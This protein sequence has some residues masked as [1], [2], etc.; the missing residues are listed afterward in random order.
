VTERPAGDVKRDTRPAPTVP[1]LRP[2]TVGW[3]I[4][5]LGWTTLLSFYHLDGG[6]RFEPIDCWVAQTAREM[7]AA[8]DWLIPRFSGETRMQKSPGPYWAVMLA[9]LVRGTPVDE[10]SARIPNAI[11]AVVLVATIFWLTRRIAGDRAAI[12]AGFASSASVLVLWWSHRGASDLGLATCTTLSLATLWIAAETEPPGWKR[13]LQWLLGYFAAGL[14]MLYK[15]PMPLVVVGLPALC[16]LLL[17]R[18]WGVLRSRWHLVGLLLFLLPWLPWAIAVCFAEDGA[19]WKWKVE[20]L[21]RFTGALPNVAEQK[22]WFYYC[23]YLLPP[24]LY[25]LPFTLSLPAALSRGWRKQPG[26][27]RDGTLFLL[28]WFLSL[29]A[30]FTAS[31]GKELRYFL[32]ALPPLLVLLGV[33][34]AAFFDPARPPSPRRD[35][36]G[37]LAVWVLTPGSLLAGGLVGLRYWFKHSGRFELDG[38]YT[39]RDVWSA[40]LVAALIVVVGLALAAWL[41]QSRREHASF[42]AIV[43]TMWVMWFWTW[44]KVMPIMMSQRPF[45]DFAGQL[46]NP[47]N[48]PL[49]Y[50]ACIEQVGSQ[51]SRIIWYSDIRYPRV[52]DQLAIL[53]EQGGRRSLNYEIRRTGETVIDKLAGEAPVLFVSEL[54]NYVKLLLLAPREL[55]QRGRTMPPLHLW[56]QSAYGTADRHYVLFGNRPPPF[57]EPDLRVPPRQRAKLEAAGWP[58]APV[59][60]PAAPAA[61]RPDAPPTR[62]G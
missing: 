14:G 49:D 20:F 46:A 21:D 9:S 25:C 16:Y 55:A 48:V 47:D 62:H 54:P 61:A 10:V 23:T 32:P 53:K 39:W 24:L 51:D 50:R 22:K 5:L 27:N 18:R 1:P 59:E 43:A 40:Y 17:C 44:P 2:V 35:R 45:I 4:A 34:L 6:A 26:V 31:A 33:E 56:L 42:A 41:Y 57:P 52:I 8:G 60:P 19:F 29:L 7:R 36:V 15:M 30:F 12:F 3:L 58:T 38:L 37:A 11:A 13:N 28:I